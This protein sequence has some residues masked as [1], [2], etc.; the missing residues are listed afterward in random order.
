FL[1]KFPWNFKSLF[2]E[3]RDIMFSARDICKLKSPL[4]GVKEYRYP[5]L[6]YAYEH[7]LQGEDPAGINGV[8]D[9]RA[10]SDA[11]VASHL[12]LRMYDDGCYDP[13]DLSGRYGR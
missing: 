4:Y 7:I 13:F 11:R 10:L 6:D 3:C 2:T 1:Y 8:Q 9:H 12:M 5:K